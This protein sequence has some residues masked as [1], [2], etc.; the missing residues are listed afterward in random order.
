MLSHTECKRAGLVRCKHL[1]ALLWGQPLLGFSCLRDHAVYDSTGGRGRGPAGTR[2]GGS[3]S[4]GH[5]HG[6]GDCPGLGVP[7]PTCHAGASGRRPRAPRLPGGAGGASGSTCPSRAE[8]RPAA[9]G[10]QPASGGQGEGRD[11]TRASLLLA[12]LQGNGV[13]AVLGPRE[14]RDG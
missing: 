8:G 1:A 7:P 4:R 13:T 11:G 12:S 6:Q 10:S 2:G 5:G 9:P 3:R 14:L